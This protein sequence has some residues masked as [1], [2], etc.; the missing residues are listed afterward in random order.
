MSKPIVRLA[1]ALA[2]AVAAIV[3]AAS[4]AGAQPRV[5][6]ELA[7]TLLLTGSS[8]MAPLVTDIAKRFM[9]RHPAVH[10]TVQSGGSGRGIDDA[11]SGKA[12]IGM[13]SRALDE[14]EK[15]LRGF[16][17]GRDGIAVIVHKSN[18][19]AELSEDQ[20]R[21]IFTGRITDWRQVGGPAGAIVFIGRTPG[22]GSTEVLTHYLKL[23]EKEFKVRRTIGD[24]HD[25][26][27][28]IA[29]EPAGI[30][31]VSS[32][33]AQADAQGGA[34]IRLL[35]AGGIEATAKNILSGDYPIARPLILVTRQAPTG[36]ARAFIDFALSPAVADLLRK[37]D[38]IPYED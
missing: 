13:A 24:N 8:T 9:L 6:P 12:A 25:L 32:G 33:E 29:A 23:D 19:V 35:R 34:Q 22:R 18:A 2:A 31:Y 7:G 36:I 20:L 17:I 1:E 15:D 26:I 10:I 21:G 3:L 11:R 4:P 28:A 14:K 30:A 5:A 27:V 37:H 16:P 38:F